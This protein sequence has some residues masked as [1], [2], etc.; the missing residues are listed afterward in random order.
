MCG[1]PLWLVTHLLTLAGT[2]RSAPKIS[3]SE[4]PWQ[5]SNQEMDEGIQ[6][7]HNAILHAFRNILVFRYMFF[8]IIIVAIVFC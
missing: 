6:K 2:L 1:Y 5:A 3:W 8:H 7:A 4:A